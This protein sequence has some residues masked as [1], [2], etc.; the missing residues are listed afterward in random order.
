VEVQA[1]H[2]LEEVS[3]GWGGGDGDADGVR[4]TGGVGIGAE[5]GVYRGRGVEVSD[6]FVLQETP[7]GR[8][9]DLAKAVV[10]ATDGGYGPGKR[11]A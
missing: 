1:C 8:V 3:G 5:E 11:P 10:G 2:C 4:K 7:D 6:G 9:I